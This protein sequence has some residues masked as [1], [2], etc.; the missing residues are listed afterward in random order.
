MNWF[1]RKI[2]KVC[3]ECCNCGEDVDF[4]IPLGVKA[5]GYKAVCPNCRIVVVLEG[6][7]PI[8]EDKE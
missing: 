6:L 5:K 4:K 1:K 7:K 8:E 2:Y 3:Y